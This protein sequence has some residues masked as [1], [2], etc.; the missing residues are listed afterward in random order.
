MAPITDNQVPAPVSNT[1]KRPRKAVHPQ[2]SIPATLPTNPTVTES[3][4]TGHL[5]RDYPHPVLI[6]VPGQVPPSPSTVHSRQHF[7]THPTSPCAEK[8]DTVVALPTPPRSVSPPPSSWGAVAG[9]PLGITIR[10]SPQKGT[11][12]SHQ[13]KPQPAT[14]DRGVITLD[15]YSAFRTNPQDL[16][17]WCA[18]DSRSSPLYPLRT[19]NGGHGGTRR[20]GIYGRDTTSETSQSHSPRLRRQRHRRSPHYATSRRAGEHDDRFDQ[21]S[22]ATASYLGVSRHP[23]SHD[24]ALET[25]TTP[26]RASTPVL[27]SEVDG[28][29]FH[30]DVMQH[31]YGTRRQQQVVYNLLSHS[32]QASDAND[33]PTDDDGFHPGSDKS[34]QHHPRPLKTPQKKRV[35]K[36]TR[37]Y[38]TVVWP[39][40][41]PMDIRD[42]VDYYVLTEPE[43]HV[44]STLRVPPHQYLQIK[45]TLIQAAREAHLAFP[46]GLK[47]LELTYAR[48]ENRPDAM[49]S[50]A[51]QEGKGGSSI[52]PS[53]PPVKREAPTNVIPPN[54]LNIFIQQQSLKSKRSFRKRDAQKLCRIDVN[55]TSKI[56]DW[57]V[58]M[59]WLA[60][61]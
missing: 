16:W 39:K 38:P 48:R 31:G 13:A 36:E 21:V 23:A 60:L 7:P 52:P 57:F 44:C 26:S 2:R 40:G 35:K 19:L 18:H 56:V 33:E 11:I 42:D 25:T 12:F 55:K 14:D 30:L 1:R 28:A 58:E 22:D 37:D 32:A 53:G 15:V 5:Q 45:E 34:S 50:L 59:G 10:Y 46:K 20:L 61:S 29:E 3:R 41:A 47:E 54:A 6:T 9:P 27:G 24:E 49:E 4:P 8:K 17:Q 51:N 43:I